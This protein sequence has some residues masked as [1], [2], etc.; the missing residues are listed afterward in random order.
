MTVGHQPD[1]DEL[2]RYLAADAQ[3]LRD[4][5][6]NIAKR[7]SLVKELGE[8]GLQAPPYSMSPED[9]TA[10]FEA[11]NHMQTVYGVYYGQI[12]QPDPFDFDDSLA[13]VRGGQ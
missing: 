5:M 8:A 10:F 2:N 11:A 4:A 13:E 3:G 12:G 9:A 7:W 1:A 6:V